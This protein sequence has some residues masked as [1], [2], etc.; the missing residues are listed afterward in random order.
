MFALFQTTFLL[1]TNYKDV[2][3]RLHILKRMNS[4]DFM[5][6]PRLVYLLQML[7]ADIVCRLAGRITG[8]EP[9]V[10]LERMPSVA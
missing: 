6:V 1:A 7:K 2:E 3:H 9:I 8:K 5:G 4:Y 10:G